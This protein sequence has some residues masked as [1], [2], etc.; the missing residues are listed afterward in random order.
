MSPA[1]QREVAL[2]ILAALPLRTSC[3]VAMLPIMLRRMPDAALPQL[4]WLLRR[5]VASQRWFLPIYLQGMKT[6]RTSSSF[7][8]EPLPR[9]GFR[10]KIRAA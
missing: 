5:E 6:G 2:R 1:R 3:R 9:V 10:A 8:G 4:L 7:G